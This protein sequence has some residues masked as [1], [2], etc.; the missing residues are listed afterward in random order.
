MITAEFECPTT[1]VVLKVHGVSARVIHNVRRSMEKPKPV[2]PKRVIRAPGQTVGGVEEVIDDDP[3]YL[4]ALQAWSDEVDENT[5]YLYADLAVQEISDPDWEERAQERVAALQAYNLSDAAI[6]GSLKSIYVLDIALVSDAEA[7]DFI[8]F[9]FALNNPTED[10]IGEIIER[11]RPDVQKQT[12]SDDS[13]PKPKR[14]KNKQRTGGKASG[15][16]EIDKS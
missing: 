13:S 3:E 4:A 2:P 5:S 12:T 15:D 10:M 16:V 6:I 9:I 7:S 8:K 1:K 11:F 14:Q